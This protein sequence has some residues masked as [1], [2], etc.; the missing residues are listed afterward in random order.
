MR[1]PTQP[2][3][4][5]LAAGAMF[6]SVGAHA[7]LVTNGSFEAVGPDLSKGGSYCYLNYAPLEC[8]SLPGWT[9]ALPVIAS[10][11]GAWGNPSG[12]AGW[13]GSFGAVLAGLQ[14]TSYVQQGLTLAA[15]TYTL[16]WN[17]AGRAGYGNT[18]YDVYYGSSLLGHFATTSGQAWGVHSVNFS[19]TGA[20]VLKFQG[21]AVSADGTAFIDKV[22]VSVSAVPEPAS[23]AM[24]AAGLLAVSLL[25]RRSA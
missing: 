19:A 16:T 11:S 18:A 1:V 2:F 10:T 9:G 17:D 8:G 25:R 12:M 24:L 7:Q 5:L 14:N 3:Q 4:R 13:D 23:A 22:A 20:D 6:V 15:G 21:L